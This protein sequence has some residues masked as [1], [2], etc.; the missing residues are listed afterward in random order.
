MLALSGA[1]AL[2][3]ALALSLALAA[4]PPPRGG[5]CIPL[6]SPVS[7]SEVSLRSAA[8]FWQARRIVRSAATPS[9]RYKPVANLD[10]EG[11]GAGA[12]A[13]R[14]RRDAAE[15]EVSLWMASA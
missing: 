14:G 10:L 9:T 13:A 11:G 4:A 15:D 3:L 7:A 6:P 1:L 8:R 5:D 12:W 2:A